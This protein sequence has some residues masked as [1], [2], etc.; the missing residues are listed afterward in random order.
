MKLAYQRYLQAK[1]M[2]SIP[3]IASRN[4]DP[5]ELLSSNQFNILER[6]V[7]SEELP[8]TM[9]LTSMAKSLKSSQIFESSVLIREEILNLFGVRAS[10]AS[11]SLL[12]GSHIQSMIKQGRMIPNYKAILEYCLEL[13]DCVMIDQFFQEEIAY[14]VQFEKNLVFKSRE[15]MGVEE[16]KQEL[17]DR[18]Y[19]I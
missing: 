3:L 19:V 14:H 16:L 5:T 9:F 11:I 17:V 13:D 6:L 1:D 7:T 15:K 2:I 18:G 4:N 8:I 10:Q 12:F